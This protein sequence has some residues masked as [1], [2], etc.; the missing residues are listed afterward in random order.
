TAGESPPSPSVFRPPLRVRVGRRTGRVLVRGATSMF[1]QQAR[2][3]QL[4]LPLGHADPDLVAE[5]AHRVPNSFG[6]PGRTARHL[7]GQARGGQLRRPCGQLTYGEDAEDGADHDPEEPLH[8]AVTS[9]PRRPARRARRHSSPPPRPCSST[10]TLRSTS[11]RRCC[12]T[13][14]RTPYENAATL[15]SGPPRVAAN[16]D[17]R[18][19]ALSDSSWTFRVIA[20]TRSSWALAEVTV[21]VTSPS[22]GT[23]SSA[24]SRTSRRVS[25][26]TLPSFT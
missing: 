11:R 20:S 26:R 10:F 7:P 22:I 17:E 15:T 25:S 3:P 19:A 14:R 5:A 23:A 6:D 21:V 1:V 13:A 12:R 2:L 4:V 18:P 24:T 9:A 8:S 16:R